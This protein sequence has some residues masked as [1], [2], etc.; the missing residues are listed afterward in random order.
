MMLNKKVLKVNENGDLPDMSPVQNK[1]TL[2]VE[3]LSVNYFVY[4]YVS[5]PVCINSN[6]V[7]TSNDIKNTIPKTNSV[8][9][10]II[11]SVAFIGIVIIEVVIYGVIRY[12]KRVEHDDFLLP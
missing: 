8:N 11:I 4:P 7:K 3:P 10:P 9:I 6:T 2:T 1:G 12:T 5:V